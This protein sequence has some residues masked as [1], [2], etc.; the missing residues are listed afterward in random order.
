MAFPGFDFDPLDVNEVTILS[1]DFAKDLEI[2]ETITTSAWS[3]TVATGTDA[4][5]TA[6]LIGASDVSTTIVSHQFG[7]LI[8]SVTY[9]LQASI[10][11]SLSNH[12]VLWSHIQGIQPT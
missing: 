6:R 5:P 1:F 9:L 7:T 10:T 3:C 4:T 11:T 8:A 12:Y 2:G